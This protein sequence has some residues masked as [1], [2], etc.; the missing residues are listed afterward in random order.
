M[1]LHLRR[2]IQN[3]EPVQLSGNVPIERTIEGRTDVISASPVL[4]EL[5]ASPSLDGTVGVSGTLTGHLD[6]VCSR[7]LETARIELD[8]PFEERFKQREE[9][10]ADLEDDEDMIL[11][12]D[13][14]IELSPYLEEYLTLGMPSA[15][16]CKEDCKGLCQ[17]CGS[18]LNETACGCDNTVI[19]PRLAGLKDF[20]K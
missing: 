18:N 12:D 3:G 19:D 15:P 11:A 2:T 6:M 16:L 20:F 8:I 14:V 5:T 10:E 13:D 7:C 4:V 17:T 1:R 9:D